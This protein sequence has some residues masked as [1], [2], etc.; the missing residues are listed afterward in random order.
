MI[1]ENAFVD[2]LA[3]CIIK[4]SKFDSN[5]DEQS[6]GASVFRKTRMK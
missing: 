4:F 5:D 2:V 6:I 3:V 1:E